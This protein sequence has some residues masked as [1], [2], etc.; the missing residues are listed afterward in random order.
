MRN[1]ANEKYV[2]LGITLVV[3]VLVAMAC[4]F[5]MSQASAIGGFCS[6]VMRILMPFVYGAVIAYILAPLCNAIAAFLRRHVPK[7]GRAAGGLSIVLALLL[8]LLV[9]VLF[10]MLV[11]PSVVSSVM[12]IISA[13][14][15]QM[16][17]ASAWLAELLEEQ[18]ALQEQWEEFS[19]EAMA[20]IT[21]WLQTD[22]LTTVQT[23][24]T[25]FGNQFAS[26]VVVVKNIGLGILISIYLLASRKKFA[27]Q[28]RLLLCGL[29]PKRW[30]DAIEREVRYADKMFNGFLVGRIIDS[31]IIGLICFVFCAIAGFDSAVLVSVIVGVTNVIPVFGPFIGA[32]PCALLLLLENPWHCL[33]FLVFVVVLQ[34]LD[35]NV[36][37]PRILGE[38]TGVDSFWVLFSVLLFGGLWGVV[39]MVVGVPLFAVLYDIL[40]RLVYAG[41]ARNGRT[42]LLPAEAADAEL[43]DSEPASESP[44]ATE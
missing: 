14:P 36:L 15:G 10:F 39:G 11:I 13:V 40:K 27:V 29:F 17:T 35:G 12:Q 2:K 38:T 28:A 32:I 4:V 44:A 31:A 43:A 30:A 8:A 42:D 25:N 6:A 37:G 9:V 24:A 21:S 33:A 3:A 19:A 16:A 18:P 41:L 1:P 20:T 26:F 7:L 5:V 22:L 34:L 23:V